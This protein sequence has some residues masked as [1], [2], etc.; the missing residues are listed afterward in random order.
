MSMMYYIR[1]PFPV[2][3]IVIANLISQTVGY[4]TGKLLSHCPVCGL[5]AISVTGNK[6]NKQESQ[7][8]RENTPKNLFIYYVFFSFVC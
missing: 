5:S 7:Y 1:L 2:G 8:Y 4:T 6:T 3:I